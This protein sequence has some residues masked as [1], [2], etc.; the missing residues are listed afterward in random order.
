MKK[1]IEKFNITT[2]QYDQLEKLI[3]LAL[4]YNKHTN[5]TAIKTKL[6]FWDRQISD[7]LQILNIENL[8]NLKIIDVGTGGGFPGLVLAIVF[9]TS[10][11]FLNDSNNK[12][13]KFIEHAKQNLNL[14]N[15]EI[16]NNRVENLKSKYSEKF[17]LVISRAVAPLNILIEI[18]SFLSKVNGKFIFWKGSN[19]ENELPNDWKDLNLLGVS[20]DRIEK[21]Y[22]DDE[23]E[24]NLLVLNKTTSTEK[25]FPREYSA[26]KS[27]P[28]F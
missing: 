13:I 12:K 22:L 18:T 11:F 9:P 10:Q 17:D 26:I 8:E 14:E 25:R 2:E 23:I 24:R 20:N 1:I 7:S 21:Y 5:I 3:D 4:E 19:L 27:K 6:E 28:L 16:L 15:V